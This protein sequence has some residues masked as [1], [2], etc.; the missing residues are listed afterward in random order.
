MSSENHLTTL[1]NFLKIKRAI[2]K[3]NKPDINKTIEYPLNINSI[4]D[5]CQFVSRWA[6]VGAFNG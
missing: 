1:P 2:N 4:W 3:V 5:N 6:K